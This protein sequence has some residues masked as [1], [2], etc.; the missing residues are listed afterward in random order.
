[1]G[2]R[3]QISVYIIQKLS[4]YNTMVYK[5]LSYLYRIEI[6]INSTNENMEA[7]KLNSKKIIS[8]LMKGKAV[9]DV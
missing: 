7:Q 2:E 6:K 9:Y 8:A 3:S 4:F 5:T 1:M